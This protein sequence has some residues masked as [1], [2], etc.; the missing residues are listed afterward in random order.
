M[1]TYQAL[2][3]EAGL[4]P[5]TVHHIGSAAFARKLALYKARYSPERLAKIRE[6]NTSRR[7]SKSKRYGISRRKLVMK[8]L[9]DARKSAGLKITDP[10][11]KCGQCRLCL[12]RK[13]RRDAEVARRADPFYWD[14]EESACIFSVELASTVIKISPGRGVRVSS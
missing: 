14:N 6:A 13:R 5:A 11:C 1:S 12:D 8:R 9:A 2:L 7:A 3:A 10:I 4:K